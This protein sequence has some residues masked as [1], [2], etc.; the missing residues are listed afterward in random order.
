VTGDGVYLYGVVS[1]AEAAGSLSLTGVQGSAVRAVEHDGIAALV[2]DVSGGALAAAR[3]LRAHHRTLEA[4]AQ[5]MTVLPVRFG[6]VM[7]GDDAV[8][9][10]MLE[11]DHERLAELLRQLEGHVQL[12]VKGDYDEDELLREIVRETPIVGQLRDRLRALPA[13]AGYY[14]RIRLGEVVA[15]EVAR[16]REEDTRLAVDHLEPLATAVVEEQPASPRSAFKLACL[17]PRERERAFGAAVAHVAHEL[18]ERIDTRF[19]G[20]LPPYSFVEAGSESWV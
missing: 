19:V 7:E 3:E 4:V 15:A 8:R 6:T 20:P 9:E 12:T 17:V 18:G 11:P 10:G 1:A 5:R 2:S 14:E 16:R 13:T